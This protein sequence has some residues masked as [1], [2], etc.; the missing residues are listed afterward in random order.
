GWE[1]A[2]YVIAIAIAVIGI[3]AVL[4]LVSEPTVAA[5]GGM[6]KTTDAILPG[7]PFRK[8][9][10]TRAWIFITLALV[11]AATA[12]IAMRQN[13]VD[14]Y[15]QTGIDAATVSLSLSVLFS[16]SIVGLLIGGTILDRMSRPWIVAVL[17]AGAPVGLALALV[18]NGSAAL[19]YISMA[20][21]GIV[22]GVESALGPALIAK[23]FG[24]K[25][26]AALQGLTLAITSPALALSPYLVSAIK[27]GSGSYT[28]P[29][30][31]LAGITMIAVILTVLLPKYPAP[32]VLH[33]PPRDAAPGQAT[34]D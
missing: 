29:L 17:L 33:M 8:A 7:V 24:L 28:V 23:Y 11:F 18:N 30:L 32:W 4:W 3:P 12:P 16:T 26:F 10:R 25:S 19:L 20:L 5:A 1:G 6:P 13:A 15:A 2:Y 21:L 14:F 31:V 34:A 9:I 27:A 22:A